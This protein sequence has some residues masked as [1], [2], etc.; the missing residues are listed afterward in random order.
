MCLDLLF[1]QFV[2][3]DLMCPDITILDISIVVSGGLTE[4]VQHEHGDRIQS[5]KRD[6][7]NKRQGDD[8]TQDCDSYI[9]IPP[10]QTYR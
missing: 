2:V 4:Y 5:P 6:V 10:P 1:V 7:L 8:N 3:A 9:N